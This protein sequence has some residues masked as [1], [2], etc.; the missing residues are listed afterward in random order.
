MSTACRNLHRWWVALIAIAVSALVTADATARELRNNA[1]CAAQSR[2]Q[3]LADRSG[4]PEV[5]AAWSLARCSDCVANSVSSLVVAHRCNDVAGSV[6]RSTVLPGR[7]G[8]P[9]LDGEEWCDRTADDDDSDV[10]VKAWLRDLV[11]GTD[12]IPAGS[13]SLSELITAPAISFPSY[14]RLRC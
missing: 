5:A 13:H 12:L 2:L 10:P 7:S 9:G 11:R 6:R 4:V 14:Q 3:P 1:A 8:C